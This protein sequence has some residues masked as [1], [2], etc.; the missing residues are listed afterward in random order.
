MKVVISGVIAVIGLILTISVHAHHSQAT[1]YFLDQQVEITG[2]VTDLRLVNPHTY[3]QVEV[4]EPNDEKVVWT[5]YGGN[6]QEMRNE[7]GWEVG[8]TITAVGCPA[9]NPEAHGMYL[10]AQCPASALTLISGE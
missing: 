5:V 3:M 10:G 8:R 6:R 1:F 2:T 9:R 7:E 4:T